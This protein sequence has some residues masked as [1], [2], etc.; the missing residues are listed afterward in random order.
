MIRYL[1]AMPREA[2]LFV[3]VSEKC[4]VGSVEIIGI[5]ATEMGEYDEKD[6]LV[7]LGYAGGHR[8]PVGALV[9]PTHAMNAELHEALRVDQLFPIEHRVCFTSDAFVTE[10]AVKYR[11]IYD[12]ELFKIAQQPHKKLYSIKIVSDNLDEAACEAF[13]EEAIWKVA[14]G[15]VAEYLKEA[16][17]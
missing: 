14:A 12:M 4:P 10:P 11:S 3:K 15:Y 2:E 5:G 16:D 6:I 1:F 13:N 8:V 9:E 7:N 17:V